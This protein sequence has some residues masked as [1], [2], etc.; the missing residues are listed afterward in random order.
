[1][2]DGQPEVSGERQIAVTR[3]AI[4]A[5]KGTRLRSVDRIL[6]GRSGARENRR[7]YVIDARDRMRNGKQLGELQAILASY[8]DSARRLALEFPDG[9]VVAG[10]VEPGPALST[11]FFSRPLQARLV[12]GPWSSA[13]SEHVGQ[14]LRLVE[15]ETG[16]S[17]DRG[18]RG[19]VSLISSASLIRLA[20]AGAQAA[21]DARRFRMLIEVDGVGAHAEDAWVGGAAQVGGARVAFRGHVGRCLVTSRDPDTGAI[22]LPTLDI[23][24]GYRRGCDTTE[25]LAFGVYGEVLEEGTVAVGDRVL[26]GLSA[27][28]AKLQRQ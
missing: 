27:A 7:F 1:M 20:G 21:V 19:S 2:T 23:L 8:S 12:L 15:G 11:R 25:P 10:D 18:R 16:S 9:S 6:L 13:L 22:D 5:V 24:G 17:V 26:P 4:A 14:P 28:P 3:L